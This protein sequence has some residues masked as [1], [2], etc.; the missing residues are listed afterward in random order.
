MEMVPGGFRGEW[1]ILGLSWFGEHVDGY[2]MEVNG[3]DEME[4]SE[5]VSNTERAT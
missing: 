1:M 5:C 3:A 2:G 4:E